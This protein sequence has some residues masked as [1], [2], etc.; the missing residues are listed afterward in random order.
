MSDGVEEGSIEAN[1]LLVSFSL[2]VVMV[3]VVMVMMV[4]FFL[5]SFFQSVMLNKDK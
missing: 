1:L 2:V 3:V 5:L 4:V